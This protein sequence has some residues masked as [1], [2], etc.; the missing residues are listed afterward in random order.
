MNQWQPSELPDGQALPTDDEPPRP[1]WRGVIRN[2]ELVVDASKRGVA[3]APAAVST[4]S[5][6]S[7]GQCWSRQDSKRRLAQK[8][9]LYANI[10]TAISWCTHQ[11]PMLLEASINF[12]GH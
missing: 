11:H 5:I 4:D 10:I 9:W 12:T 3:S 8:Y 2:I 6:R 7:K 1:A